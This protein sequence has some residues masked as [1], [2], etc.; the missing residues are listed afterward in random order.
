MATT[1]LTLTKNACV[2]PI[3]RD[4]LLPVHSGAV[5]RV[6]RSRS[7]SSR[8]RFRQVLH[9]SFALPARAAPLS[10]ALSFSN[11]SISSLCSGSFNFKDDLIGHE[12][13]V[14]VTSLPQSPIVRVICLDCTTALLHA[15]SLPLLLCARADCADCLLLAR[16][17]QRSAAP[18]EGPG[19]R[20][21]P[22]AMAVARRSGVVSVWQ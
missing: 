17:S 3:C 6:S 15:C 14:Q 1:Y 10:L 8:Q 19:T 21:P 2:S 11:S 16:E 9:P 13:I 7:A 22:S 4:P 12:M 5:P 18:P 20:K